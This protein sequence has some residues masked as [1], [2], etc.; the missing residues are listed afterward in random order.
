[1]VFVLNLFS[2]VS[3]KEV[4]VAEVG[5]K[6]LVY[7]QIHS[8][9]SISHIHPSLL[10]LF[11][12]DWKGGISPLH[13]LLKKSSFNHFLY[14]FRFLLKVSWTLVNKQFTNVPISTKIRNVFSKLYIYVTR[15]RGEVSYVYRIN[16]KWPVIARS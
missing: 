13:E 14:N 11:N 9:S 4:F 5:K 12:E 2:M 6:I 8:S 1:M 10:T 16:L 3:A 7:T 15:Q